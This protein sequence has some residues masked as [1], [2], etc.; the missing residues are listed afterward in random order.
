MFAK[1]ETGISLLTLLIAIALILGAA[2]WWKESHNAHIK[3]RAEEARKQQE[4]QEEKQKQ[5]EKQKQE[6]QAQIEKERK[7]NEFEKS[8]S[9]DRIRAATAGQM[10]PI[11]RL[12]VAIEML[13]ES[14]RPDP[15]AKRPLFTDFASRLLVSHPSEVKVAHAPLLVLL[16]ELMQEA[17][18]AG[19]MRPAT[20]PR[21]MAAMTMQTVMFV[22][23]SSGSEDVA[24][25]PIS[26]QEVWD[27][28]AHGFTTE[29]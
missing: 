14:T 24:I 20:K 21:R 4:A 29:D 12:K 22:A 2:V 13:F 3:E 19:K 15:T 6:F 11:D 7:R 8:S 5:I 27:F 9:A 1:K 23:Q 18:D 28:V 10:D 25:K 16:T 17:S 26:A